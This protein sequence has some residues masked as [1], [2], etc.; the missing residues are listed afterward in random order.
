MLSLPQ[1]FH[2][3]EYLYIE[4]LLQDEKASN[5]TE[6][7][8]KEE[9]KPSKPVTVREPLEITL[10]LADVA[11]ASDDA[12]SSSMKK[13]EGKFTL[14]CCKII[15]YHLFPCINYQRDLPCE[16]IP[17]QQTLVSESQF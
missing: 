17:R 3:G 7:A 16:L 12:M 10:Q 14:I 4:Y 11:N 13:Y 15:M 9:K 1:S 2:S 8:K 6:E 5:K